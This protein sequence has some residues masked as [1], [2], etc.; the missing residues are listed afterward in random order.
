LEW[1]PVF[2]WAKEFRNEYAARL[3]INR[4]GP[5]R[6]MGLMARALAVRPIEARAAVPRVA[7]LRDKKS[8][9]FTGAVQIVR[10]EIAKH[11]SDLPAQ[12]FR[13]T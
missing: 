5:L 7:A 4:A 11:S 9:L 12:V 10:V 2:E 3:S 8:R 6:A 1:D 13:P